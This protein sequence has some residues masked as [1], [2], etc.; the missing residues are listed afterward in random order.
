[1]LAGAVP[2]RVAAVSPTFGRLFEGTDEASP[3]QTSPAAAEPL[4]RN[5]I[6]S[7]RSPGRFMAKDRMASHC[8]NEVPMAEENKLLAVASKPVSFGRV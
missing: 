6:L 4:C 8:P 5:P 7:Q 2:C 1:M 3:G